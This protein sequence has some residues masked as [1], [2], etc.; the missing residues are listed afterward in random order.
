MHVW[1]MIIASS[2]GDELILLSQLDQ[3]FN[4]RLVI[5]AV[6]AFQSLQS[7]GHQGSQD[8]FFDLGNESND[9]GRVGQHRDAECATNQPHRILRRQFVAWDIARPSRTYPLV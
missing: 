6:V 3:L 8:P 9:A 1:P 5:V 4:R 7:G 2:S